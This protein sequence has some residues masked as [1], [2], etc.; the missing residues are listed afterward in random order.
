MYDSR[1]KPFKYMKCAAL[2][3]YEQHIF[4][5][6]KSTGSEHE[7]AVAHAAGYTPGRD[8]NCRAQIQPQYNSTLRRTTIQV[9][10]V[11]DS[12]ISSSWVQLGP[13]NILQ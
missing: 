8:G 10:P 13:E 1:T 2:L 9:G 3:E 7:S 5:V 6:A 11:A 12:S 4:L